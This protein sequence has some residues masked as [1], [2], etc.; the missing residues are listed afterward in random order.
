[1]RSIPPTSTRTGT[2]IAVATP[3]ERLNLTVV[4]VLD[5]EHHRVLGVVTVDDLIELLLPAGL[6]A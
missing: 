6:A 3:V 1:M 5:E 2:C 4:P